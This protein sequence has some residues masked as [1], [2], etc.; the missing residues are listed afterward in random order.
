MLTFCILH[1]DLAQ[2]RKSKMK[3]SD[4]FIGQLLRNPV[5][6]FVMI[7]FVIGFVVAVTQV[8]L[9]SR[10]IQPNGF[11]WKAIRNEILFVAINMALSGFFLGGLTGLLT[12][13]HLIQYNRAPAAWWVIF[14]QYGMYFILFDTWFYWFHRL[15]HIGPIYTII[16]KIHHFSTSPNLLTT[17]SVSPFESLVNG[18]FLPLFTAAVVVHSQAI[19]LMGATQI[20]MGLYVHSG[21]ELL[22][23]WWNK[24]WLTKWFI[25]TTF[26]DQHH[27]YFKWNFG[28]YTTLWDRVCGTMRPKYEAE[29]DLITTRAGRAPVNPAVA[30]SLV[31]GVF[32]IMPAA[33]SSL[34]GLL[35]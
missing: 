3:H 23:R 25:T 22:P 4:S 24:S 26:H 15:M 6:R 18:A 29:F 17:F 12:K 28:G 1:R 10:K 13:H 5:G 33:I 21:Y 27:K 16:H 31:L 34:G 20:V 35:T 19:A 14:L 7:L 11:R 32:V 30:A 8:L 2:S 9:R